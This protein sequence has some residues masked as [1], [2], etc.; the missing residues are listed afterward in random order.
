MSRFGIRLLTQFQIKWFD[1]YLRV[2]V[3]LY[4]F[5]L[6]FYFAV[7][8]ESLFCD[9]EVVDLPAMAQF[10]LCLLVQLSPV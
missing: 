4:I 2:H 10:T 3:Y 9:F 8:N 6:V 7:N 1:L 5:N